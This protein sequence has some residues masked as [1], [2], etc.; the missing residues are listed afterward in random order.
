MELIGTTKTGTV[1]KIE[2][3]KYKY[4]VPFKI[5]PLISQ[6]SITTKIKA[7]RVQLILDSISDSCKDTLEDV[8]SMLVK[9]DLGKTTAFVNAYSK[10]QFREKPL[11]TLVSIFSL[12]KQPKSRKRF[13]NRKNV[14]LA[15]VA[16]EPKPLL[17][18][19]PIRVFYPHVCT[20][21]VWRG[22][23][24]DTLS[25][26]L[27][28]WETFLESPALQKDW[29]LKGLILQYQL[30]AIH[31]FRDNNGRIA[32]SLLSLQA[33][34]PETFILLS[35][36]VVRVCKN[37]EF[38]SLVYKATNRKN[39]KMSFDTY[40]DK[41]LDFFIEELLIIYDVKVFLP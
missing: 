9:E 3:Q 30:L 26:L 38:Y 12:P 27:E 17:R 7:R 4:F 2:G 19:R 6:L 34:K 10:Q 24:V 23:P 40:I 20:E 11:Q 39:Q 36:L 31:P 33:K 1:V 5:R 14:Y 29:F 28:D 32:R 21:V 18:D 22:P 37:T 15:Q 8:V 13:I 16:G 25:E 41:V 35:K